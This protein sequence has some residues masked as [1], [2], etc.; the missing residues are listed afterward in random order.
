MPE[1]LSDALVMAEPWW[2][3]LVQ[4]PTFWFVQQNL[5][6]RVF[7]KTR[8]ARGGVWELARSSMWAQ[9]MLWGIAWGL[10]YPAM[11]AVAV[12]ESRGGAVTQGIAAGLLAVAGFKLLEFIA[13]KRGWSAVLRFL[14]ETGRP[15]M[16]P[17]P[18]PPD[19]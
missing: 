7:T 9:P 11:P 5:K 16:S 12:V 17:P 2:P 8:A 1:W 14:R 13:E 4:I 15:T 18:V 6:K 10:A 19:A 3:I